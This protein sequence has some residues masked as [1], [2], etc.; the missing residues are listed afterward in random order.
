MNPLQDRWGVGRGPSRVRHC[1]KGSSPVSGET[2]I[3]SGSQS[4]REQAV[5]LL[6]QASDAHLQLYSSNFSPH[7]LHCGLLCSPAQETAKAHSCCLSPLK[8]CDHQ[9]SFPKTVLKLGDWRAE[10]GQTSCFD[11]VC[12]HL[13]NGSCPF[14]RAQGQRLLT[15]FLSQ[16]PY[17]ILAIPN[18]EG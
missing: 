8:H 12:F 15:C 13:T 2:D 4:S 9:P 11:L 1:Y 6:A 3:Y 5:L 10:V 7:V 14:I 17:S 16:Q 18:P